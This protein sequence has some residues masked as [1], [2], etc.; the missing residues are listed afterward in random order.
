MDELKPSFV[1]NKNS[2]GYNYYFIGYGL[3]WCF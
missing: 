3:E 1:N 2:N